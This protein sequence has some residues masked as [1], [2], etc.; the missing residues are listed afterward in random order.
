VLEVCSTGS[1]CDIM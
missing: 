1:N